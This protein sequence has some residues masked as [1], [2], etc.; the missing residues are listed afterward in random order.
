[1]L[2]TPKFLSPLLASALTFR[3]VYTTA[4]M[5]SPLRCQIA[6]SY[7]AS[8]KLSQVQSLYNDTTDSTLATHAPTTA[9]GGSVGFLDKSRQ[10]RP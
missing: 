8:W 10:G 7:L 9:T 6:I 3:L 4:S 2:P 1:M 5:V